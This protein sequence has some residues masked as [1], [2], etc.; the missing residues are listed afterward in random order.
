MCLQENF[1]S[2]YLVHYW[3]HIHEQLLYFLIISLWATH[4]TLNKS[5]FLKECFVW[6]EYI[7][8]RLFPIGVWIPNYKWALLCSTPSIEIIWCKYLLVWELVWSIVVCLERLRTIGG[9]ELWLPYESGIVFSFLDYYM[10]Q[11]SVFSDSFSS[12]SLSSNTLFVVNFTSFY[13][14]KRH[15]RTIHRS[16]AL[17]DVFV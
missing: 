12:H 8:T 7:Q 6:Y 16:T 14:A 2:V 15:T 3:A 13:I 11:I 17:G 4:S 9:E 1:I 5:S 10:S